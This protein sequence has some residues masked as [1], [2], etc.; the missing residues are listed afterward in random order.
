MRSRGWSSAKARAWRRML[1][2]CRKPTVS[3]ANN[4][5]EVQMT[6]PKHQ[7]NVKAQTSKTMS[8]VP[9]GESLQSQ[10]TMP[11]DRLFTG[12]RLDGTGL[13]YYGARYYG[14]VIGRLFSPDTVIPDL[15]N[16]QSFNRYSYVY[17]NP[18]KYVDQNG[19]IPVVL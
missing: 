8:G 5:S 19:H 16:P 9:F 3:L 14:P 2:C 6:K 13:Y 10:G 15:M 12:Q 1:Y 18:L 11:T 7:V 4:L 17:N